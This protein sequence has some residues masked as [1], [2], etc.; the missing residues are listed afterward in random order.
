MSSSYFLRFKFEEGRYAF[1]GRETIDGIDTLR[2]EYYPAALFTGTDRRRGSRGTSEDH[3]AYD[4]EFR[5]LMNK[6]SL[7]TLWIEPDAH[8]IVK[9]TFKDVALDFLPAQWLAH[10]DSATAS[11]SMT[12]PFPEVWLPHDLDVDATLSVVSGQF[13]VHYGLEYHDYRQADVTTKIKIP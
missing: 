7:V 2:V 4:D 11:M 13:S 10:V 1:V 3:R 9:Y 5:R 12:Q 6:V 8:Q